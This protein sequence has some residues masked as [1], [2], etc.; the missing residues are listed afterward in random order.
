MDDSDFSQVKW[1]SISLT[2]VE[3]PAG[4]IF[5]FL[6]A[7]CSLIP[8][9]LGIGFGTL[10]LFRRDLHTISYLGRQTLYTEYG[11]PSSHSQC[12]WF[13]STYMVFFLFIR[14][15]RNNNW[16]DDLWK[17]CTSLTCFIVSF[18]VCYSRIYLHYH[19]LSQVACGA[20]LGVFLGALW[21]GIVQVILTPM[22]PYLASSYIGEFLMLRDST[23]IPHVMWFEYT[24]SRTEAR[25]RQRKVTSRKSQ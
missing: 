3:Y 16:I 11:M 1:K 7:W 17:Y 12:V 22:F 19:T 21:F 6:L 4:D 9:G 25:S 2:H 13:F 5:G 8:F 14:V 24:S 15:Y 18:I 20:L 23:L 10:I